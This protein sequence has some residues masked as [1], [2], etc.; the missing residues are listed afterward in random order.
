LAHSLPVFPP[1]DAPFDSLNGASDSFLNEVRGKFGFVAEV[2]VESVSCSCVGRDAFGVGVVGPTEL[3][4]T[5][6]AVK[7]LPGRFVEVVAVLV[8]NDEFDWGGTPDLNI[9]D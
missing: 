7:E 5:V 9:L 1:F 8:G 2:L 4:S 6:G 3:S